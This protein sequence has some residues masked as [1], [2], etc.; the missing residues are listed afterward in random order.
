MLAILFLTITKVFSTGIAYRH[1]PKTMAQ[2]IL[3]FLS[4]RC[5]TQKYNN[6]QK[7]KK[8]LGLLIYDCDM[9]CMYICSGWVNLTEHVNTFR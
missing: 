7:K 8:R 6:W 9:W 5:F 3:L 1:R 2:E 4:K